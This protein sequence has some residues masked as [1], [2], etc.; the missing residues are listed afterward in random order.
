MRTAKAA[1]EQEVSSLNL[2]LS[3]QARSPMPSSPWPD[4]WPWSSWGRARRSTW[5]GRRAR[6]A[7]PPRSSSSRPAAWSAGS[8]S[9]EKTRWEISSNGPAAMEI[10]HLKFVIIKL[11][12]QR[13]RLACC[14]SSTIWWLGSFVKQ[15][16]NGP[17]DQWCWPQNCAH[18]P[19]LAV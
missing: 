12:L 15:E 18:W 14:Q 1:A 9:P 17:I 7:G 3:L 16:D 11:E 4:W 5:R 8:C 2:N 19:Q 10:V 6:S 13:Q